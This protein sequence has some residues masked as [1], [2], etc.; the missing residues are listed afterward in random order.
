[1]IYAL[2]RAIM[3]P[4]MCMHFVLIS[5]LTLD[6]WFCTSDEGLSSK[7]ENDSSMVLHYFTS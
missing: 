1:M 4:H 7:G 2:I 5:V 6:F 3:N